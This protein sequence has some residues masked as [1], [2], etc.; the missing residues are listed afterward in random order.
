MYHRNNVGLRLRTAGEKRIRSS[1]P[2]APKPS[3]VPIVTDTG[4]ARVAD[5][6]KSWKLVEA[7]QPYLRPSPALFEGRDVPVRNGHLRGP[8]FHQ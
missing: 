6:S 4:K 3:F 2:Q 7:R 5:S 1:F 8:R